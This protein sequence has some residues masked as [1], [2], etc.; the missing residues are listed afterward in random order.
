MS[1]DWRS[2]LSVPG[3][4]V[5]RIAEEIR[6]LVVGRYWAA[7]CAAGT[8]PRVA[9]DR[10]LSSLRPAV[11][12]ALRATFIRA[13]GPLENLPPSALFLVCD[14]L[15]HGEIVALSQTSRRLH[16]QIRAYLALLAVTNRETPTAA[17]YYLVVDG[18]VIDMPNGGRL[19]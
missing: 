14:Y 7:A 17:Q 6:A 12:R 2:L 19:S 15:A 18:S 1:A 11:E 4:E 9:R 5:L 3:S 13:S 8:M 10:A 16:D